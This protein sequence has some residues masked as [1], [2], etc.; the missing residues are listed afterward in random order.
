MESLNNIDKKLFDS[1]LY[2]DLEGVMFALAHGGG[3]AVRDQGFTPLLVAAQY[4]HTDICGL[5]LAHGSNGNE[6]DPVNKSTALHDAACQEGRLICAL[7][8]LS[9][10]QVSLLAGSNV[11]GRRKI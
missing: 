2:G 6:V 11:D 1:S 10:N 8:L 7:T 9:T 5:L 3:V 4:G